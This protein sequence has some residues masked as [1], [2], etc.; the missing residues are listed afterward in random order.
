M[1]RESVPVRDGEVVDATAMHVAA[2][3]D[4][5]A[6]QVARAKSEDVLFS[7]HLKATMMKVSDPILFGHVVRPSCPRSSAATARHLLRPVS[8][9]T[10]VWAAS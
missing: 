9:P 4:F 2:L 6:A 3:E 10:T 5:L 8:I 1:L 7:I